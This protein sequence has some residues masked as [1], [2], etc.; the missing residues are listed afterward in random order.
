MAPTPRRPL[1]YFL[2]LKLGECAEHRQRELVLGIVDV[3]LVRDDDLL[4]APQQFVNDDVLVGDLA[5]ETVGGVEIYRVVRIALRVSVQ[6]FKRR[7]VEH[8]AAVPVV[9]VSSATWL[10]IVA[11]SD[12]LSVL[13]RAYKAARFRCPESI[14]WTRPI[15]ES[16][17]GISWSVNTRVLALAME[18]KTSEDAQT[19][20][21]FDMRRGRE[22]WGSVAR[23]G[24]TTNIFDCVSGELLRD[25]QISPEVAEAL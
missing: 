14:P 22:A 6:V 5:G 20:I 25:S 4:P 13:T 11:C 9:N 1:N 10:S 7:A 8:L 15:V 21:R 18:A 3:V 12:C 24:E 23:V 2:P 16:A 17:M 19:R